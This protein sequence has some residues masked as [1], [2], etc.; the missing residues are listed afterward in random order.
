MTRPDGFD[1]PDLAKIESE[2]PELIRTVGS[3]GL[4]GESRVLTVKYEK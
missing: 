4:F 2:L 1:L 3:K